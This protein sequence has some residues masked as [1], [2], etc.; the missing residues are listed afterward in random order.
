[1]KRLDPVGRAGFTAVVTYLAFGAFLLTAII[2]MG[3]EI[4][5][6][7]QAIEAWID[8][9]GP[10]GI[11]AFALLF[12][13]ATSLL[14][15][16]TALSIM[17]GV[18][19]GLAWGLVA[20]IIGSF[21]AATLQ[22]AVSR[23]LLRGWI[24]RRIAARAS[25]AAIQR[26]VLHHE[27]KLQVLLRLTPLN[28]ATT[29]YM[30]GAAAVRFRGFLVACLALIPTMFAEV[31]FGYAGKH[32]AHISAG[33]RTGLVAHD[34][35]VFGCLAVTSAVVVLVARMAHKAVMQTVA[36]TAAKPIAI[37]K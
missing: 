20:V 18:L 37:R 9:F 7:L 11:V 1:M 4:A 22:Y 30:L 6:H 19:F 14:L 32:V 24:G 13:V 34:L 12:V 17:A 26:A 21:L 35:L 3:H 15:P 2:L 10:W 31:Y 5:H 27:F 23:R 33:R 8:R 28:P 29:S 36:E 16:E 25:L